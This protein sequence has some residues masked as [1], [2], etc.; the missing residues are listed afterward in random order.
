M[1]FVLKIGTVLGFLKVLGPP[2]SQDPSP[3]TR[4]RPRS[5]SPG[6]VLVLGPSEDPGPGE[7]PSARICERQCLDLSTG[8][9][10]SNGAGR[11][12]LKQ[13]LIIHKWIDEAFIG[14][15]GRCSAVNSPRRN[16]LPSVFPFASAPGRGAVPV[17]VVV[18]GISPPQ[19]PTGEELASERCS[20]QAAQ[21][22]EKFSG[23]NSPTTGRSP[24]RTG[25]GDNLSTYPDQ[26]AALIATS[27]LQAKLPPCECSRGGSLTSSA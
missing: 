27:A 2:G 17:A 20:P 10:L 8:I 19:V 26:S 11:L 23:P 24:M 16:P 15:L 14:V 3:R 1:F 4:S 5:R 18:E 12:S 13:T 9:L 21:I 22:G 25:G 6:L 7:I